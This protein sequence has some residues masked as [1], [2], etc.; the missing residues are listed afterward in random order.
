MLVSH[1]HVKGGQVPRL[2]GNRSR[3]NADAY[4]LGACGG[5]TH[6]PRAGIGNLL[7]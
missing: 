4:R 1:L 7:R 5:V 2:P 6:R 3:G